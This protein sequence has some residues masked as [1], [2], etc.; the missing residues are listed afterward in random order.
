[1]G[2]WFGL[3]IFLFVIIMLALIGFYIYTNILTTEC[4]KDHSSKETVKKPSK[5]QKEVVQDFSSGD[6][7]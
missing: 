2:F 4:D 7:E 6:E 5:S 3:S 1:M